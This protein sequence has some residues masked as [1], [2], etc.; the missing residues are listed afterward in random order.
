MRD[1][2]KA[3]IDPI[4]RFL[5]PCGSFWSCPIISHVRRIGTDSIDSD[6]SSQLIPAET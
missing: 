2:S 4:S 3:D 6:E 1:H 5:A